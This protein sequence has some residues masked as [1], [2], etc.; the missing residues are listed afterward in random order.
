MLKLG[1]MNGLVNAMQSKYAFIFI[2]CLTFCSYYFF[3]IDIFIQ[4]YR[5]VY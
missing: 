3:D 2:F 4:I 1:V 5:H